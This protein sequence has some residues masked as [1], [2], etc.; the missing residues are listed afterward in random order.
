VSEATGQMMQLKR[1]NSIPVAP[2]LC[3]LWT[4]A[5]FYTRRENYMVPAREGFTGIS[6][7]LFICYV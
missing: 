3:S 7:C 2:L 1:N 5:K 6:W 4:Q